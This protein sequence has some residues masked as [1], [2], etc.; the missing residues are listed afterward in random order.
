MELETTQQG[1]VAVKEAARQYLTGK[2]FSESSPP[3]YSLNPLF[4]A[5]T[6]A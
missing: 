5:P 4:I 1:E 2:R 3:M 6:G